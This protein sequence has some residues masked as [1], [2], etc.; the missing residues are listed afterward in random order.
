MSDAELWEL[1]LISQSNMG[2]I[3]GIFLSLISAYLIVPYLVGST[4]TSAQIVTV[5]V[6][7]SVAGLT[8]ALAGYA[9][10]NRAAFLLEFT[11]PIYRSPASEG[12]LLAPYIALVLTI[13]GIVASLKFMWDVRHP[14]KD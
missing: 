3:L 2:S 14:K 7:F 13:L 11:D 8:C 4:L 6:L 1:I 5:N 10:L 9:Y 12:I